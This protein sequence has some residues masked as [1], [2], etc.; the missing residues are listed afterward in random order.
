MPRPPLWPDQRTEDLRRLIFDE[1]LS[2]AECA[3]RLGITI[4]AV[5]QK[6][7]REQWPAGSVLRKHVR[8]EAMEAIRPEPLNA[9]PVK[10]VQVSVPYLP[11]P[12]KNGAPYTSIHYSDTHFPYQND[13]ALSILYQ[14]VR[15]LQ[16][17]A[18]ID[19]GDLLD[20]Y[21]ISRYEKDPHSRVSLQGEIE[22][23]AKHLA[24]LS[25]L[26]PNARKKLLMGNHE[27]RLR[28]LLWS[29]AERQEAHQV[30]SLNKVREVLQWPA[31]LGLEA[32]GWEFHEDK[33]VFAK[34]MILKHGTVVRKW[35]AYTAKGEYEKYGRCG[36]SGHTHRRGVFEHTDHNGSHAW[37][38]LGC[39]CDLNPGY[40]DDPDWQNGFNVVSWTNDRRYFGVEEV[41][42]HNGITVF[43]G[44]V[45]RAAPLEDVLQEAA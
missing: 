25:A 33:V 43:R 11:T 3:N 15:D 20:C 10:P 23:A 12:V 42:I 13:K 6:R 14:I 24:I 5:R 27:D 8:N 44:K 45:Y 40:L 16:P 28:R 18:I 26:A 32:M 39:M 29:M 34:R 9:L 17:D 38:E 19:H 21:S 2:D 7:Q 31:L 36:M 1:N 41:R 37:W 30:L 22:Q 35:S 4:P